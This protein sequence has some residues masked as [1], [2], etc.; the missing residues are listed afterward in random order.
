MNSGGSG[1][2]TGDF[3]ELPFVLDAEGVEI[4]VVG[5]VVDG[6]FTLKGS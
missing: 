1:G 3:M 4:E 2:V 6:V 5:V